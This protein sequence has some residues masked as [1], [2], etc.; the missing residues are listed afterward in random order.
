MQ[1]QPNTP[2]T[3]TKA[4][5]LARLLVLFLLAAPVLAQQS[6]APAELA[7]EEAVRRQ[8]AL[9]LLRKTLASAQDAQAQNDL[10]AAARMYDVYF[11]LVK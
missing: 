10:S 11:R 6:A 3:M 5:T 8:E 4:A 1:S 9:I 2:K 7:T